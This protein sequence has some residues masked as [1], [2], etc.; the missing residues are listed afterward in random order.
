M[1]LSSS[2]RCE[3]AEVCWST[4]RS[5]NSTAFFEEARE[6]LERENCEEGVLNF[7]RVYFSL[8]GLSA[9]N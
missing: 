7:H 2:Q 1:K 8:V 4:R 5:R 9:E 3:I 6:T